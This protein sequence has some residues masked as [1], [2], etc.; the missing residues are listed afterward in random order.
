MNSIRLFISDFM[1]FS[2]EK[3]R[4]LRLFPLKGLVNVLFQFNYAFLA[5]SSALS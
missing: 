1:C 4:P 5:A 2:H 3:T